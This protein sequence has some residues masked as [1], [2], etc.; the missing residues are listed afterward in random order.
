M[1][2]EIEEAHR[3]ITVIVDPH[4]MAE[5]RYK[6]Y[7]EGELLD[8]ATQPEGNLTNIFVKDQKGEDFVGYCWPGDSVYIDFLNENA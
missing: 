8:N 7:K 5:D 3:R 4:I 2:S 1:N 6:L